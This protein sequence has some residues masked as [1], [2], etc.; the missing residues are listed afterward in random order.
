MS[1]FPVASPAGSPERGDPE[2]LRA[3]LAGDETAGAALFRRHYDAV[4]R[5]F[6]Y[7]VGADA[8][9]LLQQT[10]LLCVECRARF[11]GRSSFR[12]F[13]FG[14]ARNVLLKHICR[15]H[16]QVDVGVTS[17]LELGRSLVGELAK[18]R[19]EQRLALAL[20]RLPIDTQVLIELYFWEGLQGDELA[21]LYAV[22]VGTV[23]SRLRRA[24]EQLARVFEEVEREG[25]A[26]DDGAARLEGWA[27]D[28]K[29]RS[30]RVRP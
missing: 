6:R 1:N 9:D 2:L 27:D 10:F 26:A 17:L 28:V 16:P 13:L 3:W 23:R 11:E 29:E 5:F 22:P 18:R 25:D 21:E 14:I 24:R 7:K 20:Q 8:A 19:D 4:A 30:G 12:A 15:K